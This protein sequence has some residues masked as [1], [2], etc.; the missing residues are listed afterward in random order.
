MTDDRSHEHAVERDEEDRNR[1]AL[2]REERES[3]QNEEKLEK[4][5][6][7]MAED[8]AEARKIVEKEIAHERGTDHQHPP[9]D[10]P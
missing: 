4:R 8:E 6:E 3:E 2:R 10:P 5:L 7:Q 1:F 9:P